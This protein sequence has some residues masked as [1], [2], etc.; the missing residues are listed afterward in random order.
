VGSF[1]RQR[2]GKQTPPGRASGVH[3]PRRR[4]GISEHFH[5]LEALTRHL[6]AAAATAEAMAAALS[7]EVFDRSP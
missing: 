7:A 4:G 5:R 2:A 6:A 3:P 1:S